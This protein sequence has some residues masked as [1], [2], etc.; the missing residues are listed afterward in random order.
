ME[1]EYAGG[2]GGGFNRKNGYSKRDLD[3]ELSFDEGSLWKTRT[4]QGSMGRAGGFG[5]AGVSR[6]FGS[7]SA[8]KLGGRTIE[9]VQLGFGA[10][11]A[12]SP[13]PKMQVP[14]TQTR[15]GSVA[16]GFGKTT[17]TNGDAVIHKTFGTGKVINCRTVPQGQMLT[18]Q[19]S[20]GKVRELRSDIAPIVKMED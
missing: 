9:G 5:G 19:F 6:G 16:S 8:V 17:Y 2:Y 7:G 10:S 13:R 18:I 3:E 14:V 11:S 1:Q 4:S 12:A 15:V 20:D